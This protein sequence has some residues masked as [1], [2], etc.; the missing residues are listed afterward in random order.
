[1]ECPTSD[2]FKLWVEKRCTHVIPRLEGI[3]HFPNATDAMTLGCRIGQPCLSNAD[4]MWRQRS[5]RSAWV[6]AACNRPHLCIVY[7]CLSVEGKNREN[8]AALPEWA[9]AIPLTSSVCPA[10]KDDRL[11]GKISWGVWDCQIGACA[12]MEHGTAQPSPREMQRSHAATSHAMRGT[13]PKLRPSF[14]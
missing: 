7:M 11:G 4:G 1:M 9:D 14:V 13:R 3:T 8:G 2:L 12:S 5:K 6:W 10:A